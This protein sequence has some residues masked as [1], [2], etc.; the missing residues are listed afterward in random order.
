MSRIED[1]RMK[2]EQNKRQKRTDWVTVGSYTIIF[3]S[4]ML[5]LFG[6]AFL[7]FRSF[8]NNPNIIRVVVT[9]DG[10]KPDSIKSCAYISYSQADSLIQVVRS[11]DNELNQKYQYL[12]EQKEQDSQLFYWGSLLVGLI[13]A[14]FGWFGF[15]SLNS[16]E[17]K[18]KR[19]AVSKAENTA[20]IT[21]RNY[22]KTDGIAAI[23]QAA[24]QFYSDKTLEELRGMVIE[25]LNGL[26]EKRLEDNIAQLTERVDKL[27]TDNKRNIEEC[28][29]ATFDDFIDKLKSNRRKVNKTNEGKEATE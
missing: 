27:E 14:I 3:L 18:A 19:L 5:L 28:V 1:H 8:T 2:V 4:V 25:D 29:A 12:I 22:M 6:V 11:Y 17:D 23:K 20:R 10:A 26:I 13:I 9:T 21:S 7:S 16:I 24:R 15:K